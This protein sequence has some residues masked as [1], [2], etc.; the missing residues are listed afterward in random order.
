MTALDTN[1]LVYSHRPESPQH[2]EAKAI[3]DSLRRRGES[4]AIPGP[5]LHEF[6]AVVTNARIF[7]EPT[8]MR[9]AFDAVESWAAGANLH[10]LAESGEHLSELRALVLR[11]KISGPRIHD[12]RIAVICLHHG[13]RELWTADRDFSA[14]PQLK[15][16]SPLGRERAD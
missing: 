6:V 14:F 5:C 4:W 13:V 11:A 16:R 10:F 9:S 1:I 8:P 3:V 2:A 15:T 7:K 12:A